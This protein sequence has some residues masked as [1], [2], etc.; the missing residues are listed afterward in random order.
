MQSDFKK[1][2]DNITVG[3]Y[4]YN[5]SYEAKILGC[6]EEETPVYT[7]SFPEMVLALGYC[8]VMNELLN[9]SVKNIIKND[10]E[11]QKKELFYKFK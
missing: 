1:N 5:R 11:Q 9:K 10:I 4:K 3:I 7:R 6:D 2:I 8:K